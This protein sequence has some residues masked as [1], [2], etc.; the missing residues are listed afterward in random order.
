M[1][2]TPVTFTKVSGMLII[3]QT[4]GLPKYYGATALA[5]GKFSPS[6]DGLTVNVT[7]GGDNY[8]IPYA[9]VQV[10]AT[11]AVTLSSSLTLLNSIFGS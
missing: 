8:N 3:T 11:R 9:D 4:S 1:A 5:E 10:T 2:T 6:S 7:V